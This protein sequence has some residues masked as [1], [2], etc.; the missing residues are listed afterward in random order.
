MLDGG[1]DG[2]GESLLA[3]HFDDAVGYAETNVENRA[4][5]QLQR[6]A[7]GDHFR[8]AQREV[9]KLMIGL[10]GIPGESRFVFGLVGLALLGVEDDVV[11]ETPGHTDVARVDRAFLHQPPDHGDR[12]STAGLGRLSHDAVMPDPRFVVHSEIPGRVRFPGMNQCHVDRMV[13]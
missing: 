6:R 3:G 7:A 1:D 13:G 11:H 12:N 10:A 4:G 2:I 8:Y 5:R 9:A